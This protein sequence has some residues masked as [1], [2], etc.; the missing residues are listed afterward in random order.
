MATGGSLVPLRGRSGSR[1]A[2][3][4]RLLAPRPGWRAASARPPPMRCSLNS[5]H[6]GVRPRLRLERAGDDA[7]RGRRAAPRCRPC[8]LI[9][10]RHTLYLSAVP[11]VCSRR[12][13]SRLAARGSG[14]ADRSSRQD[15]NAA[16]ARLELHGPAPGGC[17]TAAAAD[18]APRARQR[19]RRSADPARYHASAPRRPLGDGRERSQ[20]DLRRSQSLV[21]DRR[22]LRWRPLARP[23]RPAR[24]VFACGAVALHRGYARSIALA[25]P[26][27]QADHRRVRACPRSGI[28]IR[29][30]GRVG[31]DRTR[32]P[33][34]PAARQSASDCSAAC[35][36]S[37]TS[38]SSGSCR[39]ARAAVSQT[40]AFPLCRRL[41]DHAPLNGRRRD[42]TGRFP[43]RG[44][45]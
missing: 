22:R 27:A 17:A 38:P 3:A 44:A 34:R 43:D 30:D 6:G 35:N 15:R 41:D 29:G 26:L 28:A 1:R 9:G 33:S 5:P 31:A 13:A 19:S 40:V 14:A 37:E 20:C 23:R 45:G 36:R 25:D 24:V 18:R 11:G 2:S 42:R 7:R 39:A 10:I 16:T 12:L 4:G 21:A 32:P 8:H